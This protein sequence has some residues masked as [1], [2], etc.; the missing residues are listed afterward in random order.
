[1]H[2]VFR[3][4]A[5]A[6]DENY[7]IMEEN[8]VPYIKIRQFDLATLEIQDILITL[9]DIDSTG[10]AQVKTNPSRLFHQDIH[11]IHPGMDFIM[12]IVRNPRQFIDISS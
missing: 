7:V 11:A 6:L 5:T 2:K 8:E 9:E 12:A 10:I 1:M 4:V 3:I